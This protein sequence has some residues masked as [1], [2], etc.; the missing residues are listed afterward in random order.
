M[1]DRYYIRI[2]GEIR[3]PIARSELVAQIRKKRI[4]RHHEVSE[5]S[6]NWMRA[7]DVPDLFEP[8]VAER[9]QTVERDAAVE[10]QTHEATG[11]SGRTPPTD[12]GAKWYYAKGKNKVGPVS[13][14]E[15]RMLISTG[16]VLP[17]DL[18]WNET[19]EDW[20]EASNLPQ[21]ASIRPHVST[22][23]NRT[24]AAPVTYRKAGFFEVL[25]G[26]SEGAALPEIAAS[27]FPNLTR[28]LKLAEGS[29]R[30]LFVFQVVMLFAGWIYAIVDAVKREDA[31]DLIV[32][33][34]SGPIAILF[35]WLGFLTFLAVLE[36]VKVFIR[37]E[38]N[39][40]H[41]G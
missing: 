7:G 34:M 26:L 17:S 32:S 33:I 20:I 2:R 40:S 35:L 15:I 38:H 9:L 28:Y 25:L 5:D 27:K 1:S 30:I 23:E 29:V 19:L 31:F 8:V 13:E 4:G 6:V 24:G 3:G 10:P 22:T 18:V 36:V 12:S 39:T 37:I 21:F 41:Q 14:S 16:T 11:G